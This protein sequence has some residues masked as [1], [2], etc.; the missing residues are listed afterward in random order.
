MTVDERK[1]SAKRSTVPGRPI[2]VLR[3]AARV[4]LDLLFPPRC[5]TCGEAGA[6]G[7]LPLCA[8]CTREIEAERATPSCPTCADSVALYEVSEGQCRECRRRPVRVVG[9]VRVGHY[10]G[11]LAHLVRSYKYHRRVELEGLLANWLAE[12]IEAA[13]WRDRVEAVVPVPT[14]WTRRFAQPFYPAEQ[15]TAALVRSTSL[16]PA[17]ILRRVRA[18]PH[19][20]GLSYKARVE[21]VH[22][23]FALRR[24]VTLNNARLLLIDDVKT[25][26]ATIDE[27]ARVLLRSGASDVYAAT[28]VKAG[29]SR[30]T[31]QAIMEM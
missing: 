18:G 5:P 24:G 28:V 6:G 13:P 25:T 23:A 3:Q 21:N 17:R 1:V 12:A 9:S 4:G 11:R 16:P 31:G 10:R 7:Q 26:G 27:C 19:Q 30:S 14:H 20:I 2:A 8:A 15:L 29:W 22:G